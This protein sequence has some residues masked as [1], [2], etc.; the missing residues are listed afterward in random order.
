MLSTFPAPFVIERKGTAKSVRLWGQVRP[1]ADP[2][3]VVQIQPKGAAGFADVAAGHDRR[4]RHW[5][6]RLTIQTR[7]VVPLSLDAGADAHGARAAR[8]ASRAASTPSRTEKTEL[9][10]GSAL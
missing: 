5:T 10:A 4:R 1:D 7:R 9:R 2:T 8:R 6:Y 3:I